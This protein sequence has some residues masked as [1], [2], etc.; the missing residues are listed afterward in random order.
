M[1]VHI[2]IM[3]RNGISN[4]L[5]EG[6]IREFMSI[7]NTLLLSLPKAEI[8]EFTDDVVVSTPHGNLAINHKSP[9]D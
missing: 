5:W 7:D 3:S 1:I 6:T 9:M 4:G 8:V 2:C